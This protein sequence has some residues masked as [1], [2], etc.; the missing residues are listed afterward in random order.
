M[1]TSGVARGPP[2]RGRQRLRKGVL[3]PVA[4]RVSQMFM[5]S[6]ATNGRRGEDRCGGCREA[7]ISA[8]PTFPLV[9]AE[10]FWGNAAQVSGRVLQPCEEAAVALRRFFGA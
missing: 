9:H 2:Q 7:T 5:Y 4:V 10:K 6:F 8:Y 3:P 1:Y